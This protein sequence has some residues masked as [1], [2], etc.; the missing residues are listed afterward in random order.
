[1]LSGRDAL[2]LDRSVTESG[3]CPE[4]LAVTRV[5]SAFYLDQGHPVRLLHLIIRLLLQLLETIVRIVDRRTIIPPGDDFD[6]L[7]CERSLMGSTIS[8]YFEG[9]SPP[10]L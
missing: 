5:T 9:A 3:T 10:R 8:H 2:R 7:Q 1:M 4:V 6:L